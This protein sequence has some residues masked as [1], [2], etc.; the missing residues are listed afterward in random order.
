VVYCIELAAGESFE[1]IMTTSGW[2][3]SIYLITDCD[4]PANSCVAGADAYPDGSTFTYT[5]E[6]TGRYYLIVDAYSGGGAFNISGVNGGGPSSA[7][8][9]TWGS[10]KALYR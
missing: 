9:A 3:D 1:V 7:Q 5:A 6:T 4:D 8:P 2:D 10:V